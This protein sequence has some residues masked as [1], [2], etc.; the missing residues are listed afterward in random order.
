MPRKSSRC[1]EFRFGDKPNRE[2]TITGDLAN[3]DDE[4]LNCERRETAYL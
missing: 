1:R 4:K 2:M 3:P